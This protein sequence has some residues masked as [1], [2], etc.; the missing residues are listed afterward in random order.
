MK[1]ASRGFTLI[2]IIVS[3]TIF[4]VVLTLML[5]L[6]NYTL[7]I[8]RRSEALRQVTQGMRN[9]TEFLIKEIRNGRIDYGPPPAGQNPVSPCPQPPTPPATLV[10]NNDSTGDTALG[11]VNID[12]EQ[13]C[14]YWDNNSLSPTYQNLMIVKR[15]GTQTFSAQP[16]NP[17]GVK[18][19]QLLFHV[20]PA[21]N[22]YDSTNPPRAQ[23]FVTM[24]ITFRIQ[25]G[26]NDPVYTIPYQ[27]S[28]ST[29]QYD[30]PH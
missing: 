23:P 11:L 1:P 24:L 9:F 17:T 21:T 7:K 22:P 2:E 25:L 6:F 16:L 30:L 15:V 26:P 29:D 10:Y 27:T 3:T 12:G 13:E 8:N 4:A 19:T 5:T 14:V 20:R 18:I 28:I